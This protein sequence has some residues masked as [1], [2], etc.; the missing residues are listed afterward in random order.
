MSSAER[1]GGGTEALDGSILEG[2][3][4]I[5]SVIYMCSVLNIG[6]AC[7]ID[8]YPPPQHSVGY[9][10]IMLHLLSLP[11]SAY[12]FFFFCKALSYVTGKRK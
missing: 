7:D 2:L 1:V 8:L 9:I 6:V 5:L 10:L 3:S 11:L 12:S 4:C